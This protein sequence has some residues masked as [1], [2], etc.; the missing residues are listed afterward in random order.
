MVQYVPLIDG[1]QTK[2]R[3]L[4]YRGHRVQY[5][6]DHLKYRDLYVPMRIR[7]VRAGARAYLENDA[8]KIFETTDFADFKFVCQGALLSVVGDLMIYSAGGLSVYNGS[9]HVPV[10]FYEKDGGLHYFSAGDEGAPQQSTGIEHALGYRSGAIVARGAALLFIDSKINQDV[11]CSFSSAITDIRKVKVHGLRFLAVAYGG[12]TAFFYGSAHICTLDRHANAKACIPQLHG[13]E[14]SIFKQLDASGR[15]GLLKG[16]SDGEVLGA[17]VRAMDVLV[18]KAASAKALVS[19]C[20]A[21]VARCGL[22]PRPAPHTEAI[23]AYLSRLRMVEMGVRMYEEHK[24]FRAFYKSHRI[25]I[26]SPEFLARRYTRIFRYNSAVAD[27]RS[28]AYAI[29]AWE[30]MRA[31]AKKQKFVDRF[32]RKLILGA[33]A[34]GRPR[35]SRLSDWDYAARL[36]GFVFKDPRACEMIEVLAETTASISVDIEDI[37][38]IRQKAFMTRVMASAGVFLLGS[39]MQLRSSSIAFAINGNSIAAL[40]NS[41]MYFLLGLFYSTAGS[42]SWPAGTEQ[43]KLDATQMGID[44]SSALRGKKLEKLTQKYYPLLTSLPDR[45]MRLKY[46]LPI[47]AACHRTSGAPKRRHEPLAMLD[48][49]ANRYR[50]SSGTQLCKTRGPCA[51]PNGVFFDFLKSPTLEYRKAAMAALAVL[52]AGTKNSIVYAA[53]LPHCDYAGPCSRS[54]NAQ[55]FNASYRTLAAISASLVCSAASPVTLQHTHS[56]LLINGFS[57]IGKNIFASSLQRDDSCPP[58]EIFYSVLFGLTC[59]FDLS[60]DGALA[61]L[62][63]P[64]YNELQGPEIHR[65][66]AHAFYIGLKHAYGESCAQA[67]P[68]LRAPSTSENISNRDAAN[69]SRKQACQDAPVAQRLI[70]LVCSLETAMAS[71]K[72]LR[73]L[74]DFA[75][76][77]LTLVLNATLNLDLLRILRRQILSTKSITE[78]TGTPCYSEES[79]QVLMFYGAGYESIVYYKMCLGIACAW[80][81]GRR[82]VLKEQDDFKVLITAFYYSRTSVYAYSPLE[83]LRTLLSRCLVDDPALAKQMKKAD[84]RLR[85]R[86]AEK[87]LVDEFIRSFEEM[88]PLD[89]KFTVDVLSDFYENH[90]E[91]DSQLFDKV[92]LAKIL[93]IIN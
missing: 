14:R 6:R 32:Y 34:P 19:E 44:L 82:L 12:K 8:G 85:L 39:G 27:S 87:Q 9:T 81:S 20:E 54:A 51:V 36:S 72:E 75:L 13:V 47:L 35:S 78:H 73:V 74:F 76:I 37:D 41:D 92:L 40:L 26:Y 38:A 62:E 29:I 77:S 93:A 5:A 66:A 3:T 88:G 68:S 65:L 43:E 21:Y 7:R 11:R 64:A 63:E 45:D 50:A 91:L 16:S 80:L 79:K 71:N 48:R 89:R 17:I 53:L 33:A 2:Y 25:D 55:F 18:H 4:K 22:Q 56:A 59:S 61:A 90:W 69:G 67:S 60:L 24:D 83:I 42:I 52:N 57:F 31:G 86:T 28:M 15:V 70:G 84:K 49:V 46:V 10:Q 23:A 30:K 58:D 1:A